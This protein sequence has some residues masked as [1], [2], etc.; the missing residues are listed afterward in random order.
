ML[1]CTRSLRASSRASVSGRAWAALMGAALL[2]AP[3]RGLLQMHPAHRG[4][5]SPIAASVTPAATLA[6]LTQPLVS[7]PPL[8]R[9]PRPQ[10]LGEPLH[11]QPLLT[12]CDSLTETQPRLLNAS[13][14]EPA[15][16]CLGETMACKQ[17][18]AW[19]VTNG[20][21]ELSLSPPLSTPVASSPNSSLPATPTPDSIVAAAAAAAAAA[22]KLE[23]IDGDGMRM[24]SA[25]WSFRCLL[26]LLGANE[27]RRAK[28]AL[29]EER[30]LRT[31]SHYERER[32]KLALKT[33]R[34][35]HE[36]TAR[37]V[38]ASTLRA[39]A[40]AADLAAARGR[41]RELEGDL[42]REKRSGEALAAEIERIL[43]VTRGE[44]DAPLFETKE[45]LAAEI[46]RIRNSLRSSLEGDL[47]GE[48]AGHIDGDVAAAVAAA[49]AAGVAAGVA[50]V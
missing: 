4:P 49:V 41:A 1:K 50:A 23:E 22:L 15:S 39:R 7:P 8:Q 30:D 20:V 35:A 42:K 29:R 45:A 32:L 11:Q 40:E 5:P 17:W 33:E 44:K 37:L 24:H 36:C 3:A 19:G 14:P 43:F 18:E 28:T 6:T 38:E 47:A 10:P 25:L 31:Q 12:A 46:K 9:Q 13:L 48:V 2:I 26:F 27:W 34:L 16:H 21:D